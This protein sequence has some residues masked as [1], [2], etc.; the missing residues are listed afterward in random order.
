[1]LAD[2]IEKSDGR[3]AEAVGAS[4]PGLCEPVDQHDETDQRNETD[5]QPL[6]RLVEIVETTDTHGDAG[7][8]G[9]EAEDRAQQLDAENVIDDAEHEARDDDED[10]PPPIFGAYRARPEKLAYFCMSTVLTAVAK[11]ILSPLVS[12]MSGSLARR[13]TV[14]L[15]R[16]RQT[17]L[18]YSVGCRY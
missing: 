4:R 14:P 6:A 1:M 3:R 5:Q 10:H 17:V 15:A 8:Q 11:S 12:S 2:A 18:L 13:E 7:N 9:R 16:G